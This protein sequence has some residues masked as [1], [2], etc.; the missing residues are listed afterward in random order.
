MLNYYFN[1]W[2]LIVKCSI[3]DGVVNNMIRLLE[4]KDNKIIKDIIQS[5][6]KEYGLDIPG[7]AYFDPQ[8]DDLYSFYQQGEQYAYWVIEEEGEIIGGAGIA[9]FE[10]NQTIAELQK[11]YIVKEH[12]G[13]GF[14]KLLMNQV[15]QF[16]KKYYPAIYLET[17]DVLERANAIYP[18]YG[19]RLLSNPLEGTGHTAMNR[20]YILEQ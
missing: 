10:G 2:T 6:L 14:S 4:K 11:L 20:W 17:T 3:E 15:L 9:P 8:L 5:S 12:R 18:K 13:K 1:D 16:G 19:F 7:T